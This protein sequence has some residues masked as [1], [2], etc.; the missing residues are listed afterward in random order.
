MEPVHLAASKGMSHGRSLSLKVELGVWLVASGR[1]GGGG[2]GWTD[3]TRAWE[4]WATLMW[5]CG[6]D[7]Y[8]MPILET[9]QVYSVSVQV[10]QMGR[11]VIGHLVPTEAARTSKLVRRAS[12]RELIYMRGPTPTR[13][14]IRRG[15]TP[16]IVG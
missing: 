12:H 16:G 15:D 4:S 7:G 2:A 10:N 6:G 3:V 11:R 5:T 1:M 9:R 14:A 13:I 8:C